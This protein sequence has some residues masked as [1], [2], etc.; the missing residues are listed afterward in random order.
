[1]EV[2]LDGFMDDFSC[3]ECELFNNTYIL[4]YDEQLAPCCQIFSLLA[5]GHCGGSFHRVSVVI[6][7]LDGDGIDIT[8]WMITVRSDT[9]NAGVSPFFF[10]RL[11]GNDAKVAIEA[12]CNNDPVTVPFLINQSG[13]SFPNLCTSSSTTAGN[14]EYC[15]HDGTAAVIQ[16]I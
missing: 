16:L 5:D 3:A 6:T 1:M 2:T 11:L 4:A 13:L 10:W 9:N 14:S 7:H 15:Q 8:K 12:L